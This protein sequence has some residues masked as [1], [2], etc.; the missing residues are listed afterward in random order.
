MGVGLMTDYLL[1][2]SSV[3]GAM[4]ISPEI[5]GEVL[6]LLKP[7]DFDEGL[8][9]DIFLAIRDMFL[10]GET[11]DPTLVLGKLGGPDPRKREYL[12]ELMDIT[13]TANNFRE[14]AAIAR[15]ESKRRS[16][17]ELGELLAEAPDLDA[18]AELV[19]KAGDLLADRKHVRSSNMLEALQD[20]YRRQE[21]R[22]EYLSWGLGFLDE[23]LYA[24]AGSLVVLGGRP[25][26]G[27][28]ALALSMAFHQAKSKRV[29]FFSLETD[30]ETLFD[31]L[32]G[33]VSKVDSRRIKR[34]ELTEEDS[35]ALARRSS[36]VKARD[37][38]LIEAAGM[39]VKS[40][41][42]YALAR[43][44]D[45]VYIDYLQ[46]I[47]SGGRGSR[48]DA[49]T[50]ISMDLHTLAQKHKITVVALSQ[51]SR[52]ERKEGKKPRAPGLA[53]LRE[54]GQIEQDADIVLL[55]Y[56]DDPNYLRSPRT[57]A[58]AKNKE[59]ETGRVP[60]AFDGATQTFREDYSR[61]E[62]P[63]GPPRREEEKVIQVAFQ[64]LGDFDDKDMPF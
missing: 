27:K 57:L 25:S 15:R 59:G 14:Y 44:F 63:E 38:H 52:P 17:R 18:A 41:Q 3:L 51:L 24:H 64:D 35:D 39:S 20:F 13:P 11:I 40:I 61:M 53:D 56:R 1:A 8:G 43:Q 29:G 2:Q 5:T 55:I 32:F 28:T 47:Q 60:L 19:G 46:L 48:Y 42:A 49:V 12:L 10:D 62:P 16:L 58:I 6:T 22:P 34:R 36:E 31:R 30:R 23:G 33:S 4:L 50:Q 21:D 37:L 26:D 7:E 9:R 54:S 45:V